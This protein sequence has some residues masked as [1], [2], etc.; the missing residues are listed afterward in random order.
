MKPINNG[1]YRTQEDAEDMSIQFV[2]C[3]LNCKHRKVDVGPG[4]CYCCAAR[5][6]QII[7]LDNICNKHE[8]IWEDA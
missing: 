2:S 4:E 8:S 7:S 1:P 6:Y 3:C 5:G